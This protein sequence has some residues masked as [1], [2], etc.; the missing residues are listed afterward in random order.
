M[1]VK[2]INDVTDYIELDLAECRPRCR[3]KMRHLAYMVIGSELRSE[4]VMWQ[5]YRDNCNTF[6]ST[7]L[8]EES[9]GWTPMSRI[10]VTTKD[11]ISTTVYRDVQRNGEQLL[12][13]T[14]DIEGY[15]F[16]EKR[17]HSFVKPFVGLTSFR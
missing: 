14:I 5:R 11:F 13:Q 2:G 17:V 12:N 10:L 16:G 15:R 6:I 7:G 8:T 3:N 4:G 9:V 1:G